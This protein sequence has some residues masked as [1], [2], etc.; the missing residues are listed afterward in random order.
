MP[1]MRLSL[2]IIGIF[3][4][5]LGALGYCITTAKWKIWIIPIP[6]P[7]AMFQPLAW[8][9]LGVGAL[10]LLVGLFLKGSEE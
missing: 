5:L 7:F 10:L 6:N 4:I 1:N 9:L 3:I 2:I 8:I